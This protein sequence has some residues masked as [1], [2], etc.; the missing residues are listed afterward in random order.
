MRLSVVAALFAAPCVATLLISAAPAAQP[1]QDRASR[2]PERQCFGPNQV[3]NFRSGD[4]QSLYIRTRPNAVFELEA[5]G[6]CPDAQ[7]ANQLAIQPVF[8][9]S[10]LCTGDTAMITVPGTA[11]PLQTCRVRISRALTEAEVAAL[12]P[13]QRP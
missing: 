3:T 10:R 11:A 13:R 12:P 7:G 8:G 5:S 6:G 2:P 4:G 9:N 1:G